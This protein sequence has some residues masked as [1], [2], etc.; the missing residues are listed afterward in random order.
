ME[1][2]KIS[3]ND[4]ILLGLCAGTIG[5][6]V[7]VRSYLRS[8]HPL[9][10]ATFY[11][12][13]PFRRKTSI[14]QKWDTIFGVGWLL[15]GLWLNVLGFA[16]IRRGLPSEAMIVFEFPAFFIVGGSILFSLVLTFLISNRISR[17]KYIPLLVEKQRE[18]YSL[19][20]MYLETGGLKY[21]ERDRTD[22]EVPEDDRKKRLADTSKSLDQIGS[23]LDTPRKHSEE[24][25]E[26]LHR[27]S[28]FFEK[29]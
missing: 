12:E 4:L 24:D 27:L 2:L 9:E 23:L 7:L 28:V 20:K 15:V 16:K 11:G 14:V 10:F 29:D 25:R 1:G 21:L 26:Y 19:R 5:A 18:S 8:R 22:I 6:I 17:A 13:N 3:S